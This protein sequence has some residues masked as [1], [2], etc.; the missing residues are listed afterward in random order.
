MEDNFEEYENIEDLED[1]EDV[2]FDKEEAEELELQELEAR[3]EQLRYYTS[4]VE[5][6]GY[7]PKSTAWLTIYKLV[8]DGETSRARETLRELERVAIEVKDEAYARWLDEQARHRVN[9]LLGRPNTEEPTEQGT[10][11]WS[12]AEVQ[13]MDTL[14]YRKEFPDGWGD[15]LK[16]IESGQIKG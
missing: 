16:G 15:V 3:K 13:A 7:K 5:N 2:D 14:T 10:P 12:M 9:G 8:A 6:L 4:Q 11:K 1:V